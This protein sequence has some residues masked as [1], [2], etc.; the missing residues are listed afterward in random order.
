MPKT[1]DIDWGQ[2]CFETDSM[3]TLSL[4]RSKENIDLPLTRA[5]INFSVLRSDGLSSYRW[6][7]NTSK[8]GD[9]YVY[10]RDVRSAEKITFHASGKQH[11][12]ITPDTAANTG[13]NNRFMNEWVE[14]EFEQEA[15][16]TFSL[17]FPPWGVGRSY[18]PE[19]LTKDELLIIGH[20]EKL[21]VVYFFIVDST[22]NLQGGLPHIVLGEVPLRPGKTLHIIAWKEPQNNLL[23][24]I[25]SVIP[26]ASLNFS[27]QD[28]EEGDYTLNIHG[29]RG[30]NSAYMVNVPVKYTPPSE[31]S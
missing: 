7:V 16:A 5:P 2:I 20:K 13:M 28:F 22:D 8:N 24:R 4:S 3:Q 1:N 6:G 27:K 30:V 11:I 31:T 26:H 21:V 29:Y 18:G 12:S 14:P 9:A 23:E 25:H 19:Q 17:I 10:C 15:I